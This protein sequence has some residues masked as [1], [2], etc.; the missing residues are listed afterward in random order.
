M[1]HIYLIVGPSGTGKTTIAEELFRRYG[2]RQVQSYTDRP[3]R[4]P[5]EKGHIFLSKEEFDAL[6]P[7]CSYTCFD[8][9]RY[10]TT[11]QVIDQNELFVVDVAG[12]IYFREHY[13][14]TKTPRVICL[15][16]PADIA[17]SRMQLRGDSP[18][19][20]R[21]RIENDRVMFRNM[22]RYADIIIDNIDL[23]T[24]VSQIH[25]YILDCE[26]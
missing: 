23:D 7:L 8:G 3:I 1:K 9:K 10:G 26:A 14:G 12:V 19:Q 24:A 13:T 5:G 21:S 20:V 6:P 25:D 18:E 22:D 15:H 4:Y 17:A 16:V 11:S 2:Y